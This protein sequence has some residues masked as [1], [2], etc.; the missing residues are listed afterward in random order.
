LTKASIA[1]RRA[2]AHQAYRALPD[3]LRGALWLIVSA[4]FFTAMT[5][6]IKLL[7][8]YAPPV[9]ALY[10]QAAGL[11]LMIP[12][13]IRSGGKVLALD[14]IWMQIGRSLSA[15]AGV[16]LAYY[17]VQNLPLADA[18]AIS[19]TRGLWIGPLA[20]LVLRD[21]VAPATWAALLMGFGGVLLIARPSQM[22]A[23]GWPHLAATASAFLLALS[24]TGIK[25]LTRKN[26]VA[27]IMV[28]S[29]VLG[30]LLLFP[31]ALGSWRWPSPTDFL[32]LALLGG[33]SVATTASY[34]HGMAIGEAAKLASV[35]Y[36]RLPFAIAAGFLAFGEVPGLWTMLGAALI[37][38]TALWAAVSE[39][40][41]PP[42]EPNIAI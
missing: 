30:L 35:D 7:H 16:T 22:G 9:Q 28:W 21:R 12:L 6:L 36:I 3:N 33:V 25:I 19:F 26:S 32:L 42:V 13:V 23:I 2:S 41:A 37:V 4:A 17:A 11:L 1:E 29:S 24:V 5:M 15:A 20:A 14:G 40:R 34:I 27:T 8:G 38:V 18:N 31:V 39:H 10:S